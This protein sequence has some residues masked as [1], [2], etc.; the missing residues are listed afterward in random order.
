MWLWLLGCPTNV[1]SPEDSDGG[2]TG[3]VRDA[4]GVCDAWA[5]MRRPEVTDHGWSASG[6]EVGEVDPGYVESVRLRVNGYRWLAGLPPTHEAGE[7]SLRRAQECAVMMHAA[8][9][10]EHNPGTSWPCY[11]ADGAAAA[12]TSNLATEPGLRAIDA[13]MIDPGNDDTLGHRRWVLGPTLTRTTIGT[14]SA[15]ACLDVIEQ[16]A[17][18]QEGFVTWPPSGLFP[19]TALEFPEGQYYGEPWKWHVQAS[20]IDF[21][22]VEVS[23]TMDGETLAPTTR[24]LEGSAAWTSG[25]SLELPTTPS[26][27]HHR[28]VLTGSFGEYVW[29]TEIVDCG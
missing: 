15:A 14:T 4:Q 11:T 17:A 28:I 7:D 3:R 1:N 20:G 29:E 21:S 16:P 5:D 27:T 26:G 19:R 24:V 22:R 6:C 8:G 13:F 9:S 18:D 12:A 25:L 2:E 10:L 23:W